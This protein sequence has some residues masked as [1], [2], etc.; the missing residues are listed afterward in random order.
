LSFEAPKINQEVNKM[1]MDYKQVSC[2][3]SCGFLI[4]SHDENEIKKVVMDHVKNAHHQ[5]ISGKDVEKMMTAA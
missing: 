5:K 2:D 4:K 3:P 1:E